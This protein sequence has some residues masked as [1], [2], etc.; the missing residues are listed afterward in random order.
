MDAGTI[1]T[2]FKLALGFA[3]ALVAMMVIRWLAE[4]VTVTLSGMFG[5][6]GCVKVSEIPSAPAYL[7]CY[8]DWRMSIWA[9]SSLAEAQADLRRIEEHRDTWLKTTKWEVREKL[10]RWGRVESFYPLRDSSE[11]IGGAA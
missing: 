5:D 2:G 4:A 11:R 7:I 3:G 9:L 6:D 10:P 1:W 8:D